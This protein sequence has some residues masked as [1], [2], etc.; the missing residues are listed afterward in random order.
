MDAKIFNRAPVRLLLL[1]IA[2]GLFA[3]IVVSTAR[4][5][6]SRIF[7]K[8][9]LGTGNLMVADKAIEM[10]PKDAEAHRAR[11]A[12]LTLSQSLGDSAGEL[13]RAVSLRA[14]DYSLWVD[15]GLVRDQVGDTAGALA[16]FDE[17]VKRA[18]FY[19]LPRWQRGNLLLRLGQ[20][21]SALNDLNQSAQSNPELI[22]NF[23]DL[24]W[25]L[26][27]GDPKVVQQIVR[28]NSK[29]AH[30]A[31]ANFFASHG[32]PQEAMSEFQAAGTTNDDTRRDLINR[33]FDKGSF[34]EAYQVWSAANG[35]TAA[36]ERPP[37]QIFDGG[38]E[39]PLSFDEGGFSWRIPRRLQATT[40]SLDSSQ[41]HTGSKSLRIEFAGD[42]NPA[43]DLVSQLLLVEPAQRYKINFAARS[44]EIVSGGL[45]IIT[46][47]DAGAGHKRLGQSLPLLKG[48]SN[49]NV[50]SF[51][52]ATQPTSK[53]V[54]LSVQ[55]EGCT[56]APCPIFG[57]ISLDSFSIEQLK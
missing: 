11:A 4:L 38:F 13:E 9:S 53:A 40:V 25:N 1:L 21:D 27:H 7:V 49:W 41:P 46:V 14:A 16:A 44:Q 48:S 8:Y 39:A 5:G 50:N 57:A 45:P 52:F 23:I 47:T 37:H 20:Y 56:A 15:L 28:I 55:R 24:A 43:I 18:P 6:L 10:S 17:A 33:L 2:I 34:A 51:E 31:M 35:V 12:V 19:A 22:P 3:W 42:S 29:T 26:S 36:G 54:V 30:T 32:K